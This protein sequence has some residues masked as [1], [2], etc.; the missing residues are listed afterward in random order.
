[1]AAAVPSAIPFPEGDPRNS[2]YSKELAALEHT[3]GQEEAAD[4]LANEESASQYKYG[5]EQLQ[6]QEPLAIKANINRANSEGLLQ[7]GVLAQRQGQTQVQYQ[8]KEH[9]LTQARQ[10]AVNKYN[11]GQFNAEQKFQDAQAVALAK[12]EEEAKRELLANPPQPPGFQAINPGGIRTVEG[13][14]NAFGQQPYTERSRSGTVKIG[15]GP[16]EQRTRER[17]ARQRAAE[18]VKRR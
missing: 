11:L 1:M 6:K 4:K 18:K 15:A 12:A 8:G 2:V 9:S 10:T 17:V 5:T 7:S 13:P 3:R 16:W 14:P